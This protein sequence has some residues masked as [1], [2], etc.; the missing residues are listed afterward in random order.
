MQRSVKKSS[1]AEL[2][3][4]MATLLE[5]TRKS[6]AQQKSGGEQRLPTVD[7]AG[8]DAVSPSLHRSDDG[9]GS[10]KEE[11]GGAT[12]ADP[13]RGQLGGREQDWGVDPSGELS[14]TAAE[15]LR[16]RPFLGQPKMAIP[17]LK[18]RENFDTFSKQMR[19]YAKL[20]GFESVFDNDPYV[21]VG[22]DGND[23]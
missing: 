5:T 17:V 9:T 7:K 23:R 8:R 11:R 4:M 21:E 12:G 16:S 20:H 3:E 13:T 19:V 2:L 18:D 14:I 6:G 22:A 15:G 1:H 10:R